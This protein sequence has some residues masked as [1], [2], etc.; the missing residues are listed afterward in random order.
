MSEDNKSN[1]AAL[2][3]F[4][5]MNI[6]DIEIVPGFVVP[7]SG[8]Y[9]VDAEWNAKTINGKGNLSL[10]MT[11]TEDVEGVCLKGD[12]F[13]QLFN[14]D[15]MKYNRDLIVAASSIWGVSTIGELVEA[16]VMQVRVTIKKEAD[17]NDKEKF[18][19][20]VKKIEAV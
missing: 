7:D 3:E 19:C 20:R 17:K 6:A 13:N 8:S 15:G 5:A 4:G 10:D 14:A 12:K 16:G 2:E 11:Q 18:Y 9:V 1:K